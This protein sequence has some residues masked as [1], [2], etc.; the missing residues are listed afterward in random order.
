MHFE[1]NANLLNCFFN[2][3]IKNF[4]LEKFDIFLDYVASY[5][6]VDPSCE[7]ISLPNYIGHCNLALTLFQQQVV[8]ASFTLRRIGVGFHTHAT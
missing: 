8:N 1:T 5:Y 7:S 4:N 6:I 3:Y 2:N